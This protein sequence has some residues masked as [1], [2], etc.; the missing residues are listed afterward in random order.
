MES[1][2]ILASHGELATGLKSA[3][4]MI[5][6]TNEYLFAFD[7]QHYASPEDIEEVIKDLLCKNQDKKIY[8][9]CDIKCG[10]IHNCLMKFCMYE[11]V[12]I[13]TGMNLPLVLQL[14][15]CK[16]HKPDINEIIHEA[17]MNIELFDK[18]IVMNNNVEDEELW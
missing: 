5:A 16:N 12:S 11:N 9:C 18:K 13:I 17:R 4:E 6:G 7:L 10:S 1:I 3:T 2:Y 15:L 8:I 14:I